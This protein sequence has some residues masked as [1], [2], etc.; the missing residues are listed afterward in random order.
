MW[1]CVFFTSVAWAVEVPSLYTAEVPL[2][3]DARDPRALAYEMALADVL[4][5]VSGSE[6]A[7]D[8]LLVEELFPDPAAYVIQFRRGSEEDTLWVSFDGDA[9]EDVL[10][11]AG[12][13]LWGSDRPLTLIWLAVD[14]GQGDREILGA[15]DPERSADEARS[16]NR[17]SRLRERLLDSAE[18]RGLPVVFPLLDTE[19][20]QKV[21]FSDIW[22]GFDELLLDASQ[23][24]EAGS[25]LIGRIRP[26]SSQQP[27][28]SYHFAG[29]Q[30]A[31]SGEPEVVLG[32][33]ADTLAHAFAIDGDAPLRAVQ[34]SVAGIVSVDHYGSVQKLL[35]EIS[36]IENFSVTRVEGDRI[37]YSVAAH[38][39]A[40]R[41]RR[42]L[43]FGGL[44]E[45]RDDVGLDT[46][47][48][49]DIYTPVLE[50]Y[51]SP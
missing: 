43:R 18:R 37:V 47:L 17:N 39:G 15:D 13:N 16:I 34:L 33:V 9:I 35:G 19:D 2:D 5:R 21:S 46:P 45:Q 51:Y 23:R 24:Y 3:Q 14:W 6:L 7:A 20:L 10:Q 4:T 8:K 31:W 40:E 32:R 42:A 30:R 26:G 38:G 28:W 29:E 25:V 1:L 36:I 11:R 49:D 22:G 50:F 48:T 12:Q 44:V 41:L 27:R